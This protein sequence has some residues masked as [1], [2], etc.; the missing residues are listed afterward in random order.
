MFLAKHWF[1]WNPQSHGSSQS[2]K[3]KEG[4]WIGLLCTISLNFRP[5]MPRHRVNRF[6]VPVGRPG[7]D[8]CTLRAPHM[9]CALRL[10]DSYPTSHAGTALKSICRTKQVRGRRQ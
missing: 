4:W 7:G 2:D 5:T 8:P 3:R 9:H 1:L 10:S 6:D